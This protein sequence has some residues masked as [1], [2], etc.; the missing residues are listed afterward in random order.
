MAGKA[1]R[2]VGGKAGRWTNE[3]A[4]RRT[5]WLAGRQP[6]RQTAPKAASRLWVEH[7]QRSVAIEQI[8]TEKGVIVGL[9]RAR[10]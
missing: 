10:N 5:G 7:K 6:G 1:G 8:T 4:D 3:Q 2:Q 9:S